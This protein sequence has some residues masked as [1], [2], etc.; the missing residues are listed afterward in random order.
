[1]KKA[2]TKITPQAT[3]EEGQEPMGSL[4]VRWLEAQSL[5]DRL[6]FFDEVTNIF[7]PECGNFHPSEV[8]PCVCWNCEEE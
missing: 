7:C 3:G 8:Q 6:A 5:E 4:I 2:V 1:M